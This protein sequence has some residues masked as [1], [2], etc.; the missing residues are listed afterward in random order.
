MG[1]YLENIVIQ[2]VG[3]YLLAMSSKSV[4]TNK[5]VDSYLLAVSIFQ[6]F[7]VH[8]CLLTELKF[9]IFAPKDLSF[10]SVSPSK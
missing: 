1:T 7:N 3:N 6:S 2:G 4:F 5:N 9:K 10:N 8:I